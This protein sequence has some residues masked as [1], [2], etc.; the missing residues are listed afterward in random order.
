MAV[1]HGKST[2]QPTV[3]NFIDGLIY[4]HTYD[5]SNVDHTP[6]VP[7]QDDTQSTATALT[8]TINNE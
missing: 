8:L 3:F 5:D 4:A 1:L 7:H 2:T 6:P